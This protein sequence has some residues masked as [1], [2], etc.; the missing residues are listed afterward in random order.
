MR[1]VTGNYDY[2]WTNQEENLKNYLLHTSDYFKNENIT[3]YSLYLR[4]IGTKGV[5]S[6]IINKYHSTKNGRK[7][8]QDFELHFWNDTYLTNKSTSATS[9]MNSAVYNGD[10][11]NF[12][13]ETY[14][15]IISKVFNDLAP[16]GS[17]HALNYTKK[18]NA[19]EQGLK[20]PQ[21]ICWFIISKE[22]WD[23]FPPV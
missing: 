15:T 19:L 18:I 3:L 1:L 11:R 20:D 4:Y 8:H 2:P 6:N 10:R 5:G 23:N 17:A 12:T 21:A 9:T 7:C 16:A 22:H 14:Y 13:L